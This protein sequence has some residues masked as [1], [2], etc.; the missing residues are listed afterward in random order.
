MPRLSHRLILH[1]LPLIYLLPQSSLPS[2]H[3]PATV[4]VATSRSCLHRI[5]IVTAA[6]GL[7]SCLPRIVL[8]H[9]CQFCF[10]TSPPL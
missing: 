8:S 6:T 3:R 1:L 7:A 9:R 5:V 2:S 4:A 10:T